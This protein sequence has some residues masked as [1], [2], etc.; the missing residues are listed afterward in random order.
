LCSSRP[1]SLR[2]LLTTPLLVFTVFFVRALNAR[3]PPSTPLIVNAVNPGY[4]YSELRRSLVGLRAAI[5]WLMDKALAFSS[6]VGS[7][8]IVWAALSHQ[9]HPDTLR[10]EYVSSFAI[11]EVSDAVLSPEGVKVQDR[12]WFVI[13][14]LHKSSRVYN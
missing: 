12:S 9:D 8:R 13:F 3:I 14:R 10:G 5:N 7:R 1:A 6:E 4:C 2:L 11:Q